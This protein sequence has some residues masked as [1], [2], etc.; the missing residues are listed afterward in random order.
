MTML[1]IMPSFVVLTSMPPTAPKVI[2]SPAK[3]T[4]VA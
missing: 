1:D 4:N 3:N 2:N